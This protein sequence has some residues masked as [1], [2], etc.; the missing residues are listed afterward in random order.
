MTVS[1]TSNRINQAGDGVSTVFAFPYKFISASDIKVYVNNALVSTGYTVGTPTDTGANITFSVA[2]ANLSTIVIL[3][4][5]ARTQG[6]SLPSTGPFPAKTV[7]T[8][9]DKLTLLVQRLADLVGRSFTLSDGDTSAP[10]TTLPLV[11]SLKGSVLA[12]NATTGAPEAGPTIAAVGTVADNAASINTVAGI[13]ANV[14]TVA[15]ISGNVTTVAGISGNVTSVA[16]NTTNINTNATNMTDIQG[17]SANAAT[18]TTQAGVATTQ[19]GIATTQA[20]IATTQATA[21]SA[22]AAAAAAAAA[23]GL[24]RQVLDKS[25]NYTILAADGGTLF[26]ANTGGGSIA[27]TLPSI[28]AVTDGFKVSI[29][30]WTGDGNTVTINRAGSDTINGGTSVTIATQYSQTVLVADFETNTWFASTTGLGATNANVDVFSGNAST[31]AFTLSV[32]PGALNNTHVYIGGVYQ[33][34]STYTVSGTTL[35]FGSAPPSGTSNIEVWYSTPLPIGTPS[36]G[37]VSTA[38]I[39]DGAVTY[40]KI[41]SVTAGKVLGRDTS[42]NGVVQELPIRVDASGNVVITSTADSPS[43]KFDVYKAT[44]GS[45]S[46]FRVMDGTR[47]PGLWISADATSGDVLI[48]ASASSAVSGL[49]L[50][51]YGTKRLT[52]DTNSNLQFNSG[53]GSVATAYG[54]RAWVNFNGT[55]TVA[56]RASGNVSSITDNGVGDYTANFANAMPDANYAANGLTQNTGSSIN[57]WIVGDTNLVSPS[58][59]AFRF[60]TA[61]LNGTNVDNQYV[62]MNFHR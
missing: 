44:S 19:A 23:S 56:I 1:T 47:N 39:A 8:A 12:F 40:A 35:T 20:G 61:Q 54:C 46:S 30:K 6:T 60:K 2:P 38:K 43:N 50:S 17:A 45:I 11:S 22:S 62:G 36:D 52:V 32:A 34:H 18:A 48:D 13:S 3:S 58:T 51:I 29:V 15:G 53:Y 16:N 27:F 25:A 26:R 10:T 24:Y 42:G 33:F 37:T 49:S 14:T 31:T 4:D 5:P 9:L 41:Q 57:T 21:A 7:E 59:S 55:G 28:S